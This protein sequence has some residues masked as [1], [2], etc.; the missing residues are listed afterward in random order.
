M[1]EH[2]RGTVTDRPPDDRTPGPLKRVTHAYL[3]SGVFSARGGD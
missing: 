2:H 3:L 1:A